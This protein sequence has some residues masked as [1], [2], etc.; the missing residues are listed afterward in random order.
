M[1]DIDTISKCL[2]QLVNGLSLSVVLSQASGNDRL[3]TFWEVIEW[4]FSISYYSIH[5]NDEHSQRIGISLQGKT[6][7][8]VGALTNLGRRTWIIGRRFVNSEEQDCS[9][10]VLIE[11]DVVCGQSGMRLGVACMEIDESACEIQSDGESVSVDEKLSSFGC[12]QM[13]KRMAWDSFKDESWAYTG[14]KAV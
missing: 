14:W 13:M 2:T 11:E 12:E 9:R 1:Y 7:M 4:I 3:Q 8:L 6:G 10:S 5:T